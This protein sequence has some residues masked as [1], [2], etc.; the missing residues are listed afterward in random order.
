M[1]PTMQLSNQGDNTLGKK[2]GGLLFYNILKKERASL[3]DC[4]LYNYW[5]RI[6]L[7]VS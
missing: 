3:V 4:S 2:D 5:F 1:L 7:P 6:P